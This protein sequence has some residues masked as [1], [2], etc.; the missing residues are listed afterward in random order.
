MG[1][2]DSGYAV[3]VDGTLA[4]EL[5]DRVRQRHGLTVSLAQVVS[6][7]VRW[8]A[9]GYDLGRFADLV[10]PT[11]ESGPRGSGLQL[12]EVCE[13]LVR[14]IRE[15]EMARTGYQPSAA[16]VVRAALLTALANERV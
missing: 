10:L 11:G 14:D 2:E 12:E 3:R 1:N 9:E 15:G 7:A 16:A 4:E 13:Y 6:R 8:Y 5:R